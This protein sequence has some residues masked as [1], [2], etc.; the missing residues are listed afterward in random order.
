MKSKSGQ[1]VKERLRARRELRRSRRVERT[2][3]RTH[4]EYGADR[5]GGKGGAGGWGAPW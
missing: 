1:G 2:K 4:V 3:A 5:F